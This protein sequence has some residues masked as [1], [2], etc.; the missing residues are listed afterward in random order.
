MPSFR[1]LIAYKGTHYYG[2][3][4]LGANEQKA[5]VQAC[6]HNVL[7]T[8]CQYQHCVVAGASRTDAGVHAQ[9][10]VAKFTV[11]MEIGS[12]K[13]QNKMN[14][15]LPDDIRIQQ[16][17]PCPPSFN[18]NRNSLSKEYHYYFSTQENI[19]PIFSDIVI[20]ISHSHIK[21]EAGAIDIKAMQQACE[22]FIG[23]HDFF[24]FATQ[25][26]N[27]KSSIR[28]VFDCAILKADFAGFN[29]DIYYLKIIGD[30]FLKHMVRYIAGTLFELGRGNLSAK[31]IS[32][33]LECNRNE[34]LSPK[35]KA[36]GLHLIKI[37]Y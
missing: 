13:L 5:T 16:C 23:K 37:N 9:G 34:K 18:P 14:A 10:Q 3:Q 25:D 15:L 26:A 27:L 29:G 30:G 35:S 36:K 28:T 1:T 4:D 32:K 12:R 19:N 6:L 22:L 11:P 24:S 17:S 7:K 2:W 33:A 31:Q 20:P 21:Q 8:I